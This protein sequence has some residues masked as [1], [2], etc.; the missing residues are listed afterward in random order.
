[1][2]HTPVL[3]K[4]PHINIQ[5]QVD[6][7]KKNYKN[8]GKCPVST[9]LFCFIFHREVQEEF[10]NHF[11]EYLDEDGKPFPLVKISENHSVALPPTE[12]G[13]Q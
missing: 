4:M 13:K 10:D 3:A 5:G 8:S 2:N 7:K 12:G 6:G 11:H 1:M 9:L